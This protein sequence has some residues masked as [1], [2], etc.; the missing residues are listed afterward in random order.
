[1]AIA[2]LTALVAALASGQRIAINKTGTV[3]VSAGQQV[4]LWTAAGFP[5]AGSV[6]TKRSR[7]GQYRRD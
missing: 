6:P 2:S 4:S 7:T 3:T 1:M 5:A